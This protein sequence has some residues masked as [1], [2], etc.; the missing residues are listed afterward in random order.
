MEPADLGLDMHRVGVGAFLDRWALRLEQRE[1]LARSFDL[2]GLQTC[3]SCAAC[4]KDCPVAQTNPDFVP[5]RII[6]RLVAGELEAVLQSPDPWRCVDCMTC[7][8]RCHSRL[9][10]AQVFESLKRLARERGALPAAVQSSYDMFMS[11]GSLGSGRPATREKLGLPESPANGLAELKKVLSASP[12]EDGTC[13]P[14]EDREAAAADGA[15]SAGATTP[16]KSAGATSAGK[17]GG[18]SGGGAREDRP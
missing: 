8:E 4:D 5:S 11:T 6:G 9:G 13:R 14:A 12:E 1:E 10:M 7:F 15:T 3:A 17:T 18:R 2:R 16:G